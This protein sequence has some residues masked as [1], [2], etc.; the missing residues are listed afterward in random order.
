MPAGSPIASAKSMATIESS[1]VAGK[2]AM[3]SAYTGSCEIAERPRS[4]CS[5]FQT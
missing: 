3:N 4:P 1:T 2:R 5:A